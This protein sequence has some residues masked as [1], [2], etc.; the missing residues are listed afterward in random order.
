VVN[1]PQTCPGAVDW[2][3]AE[4]ASAAGYTEA[5]Y[6]LAGRRREPRLNLAPNPAVGGTAGAYPIGRNDILLVTG[7]GKGI[8]AESALALAR[9]TNASLA[10]MGRSD[11]V[12]DKELAENLARI[13][14][15]G[16]RCAYVRADVT[17]ARAVQ[18]AVAEAELRL[19][20]DRKS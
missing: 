8:A 20:P 1:V 3:A 19:G 4:V 10:L 11:P 6:D 7:G 13:A 2:I 9:P 16:V 15:A 12:V 5:H 17:D 14:A 18:G